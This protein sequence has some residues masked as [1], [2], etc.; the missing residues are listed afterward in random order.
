M[1]KKNL[2]GKRGLWRDSEQGVNFVGK[3]GIKRSAAAAGF[4]AA[5]AR[6]ASGI[7]GQYA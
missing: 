7:I 3:R 2:V 6:P 5:W 1:A 4:K